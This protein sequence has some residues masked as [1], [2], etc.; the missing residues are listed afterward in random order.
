M[1]AL[2]ENAR[3]AHQL[4]NLHISISGQCQL[5]SDDDYDG[6][7]DDDDDDGA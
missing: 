1:Y 5:W 7:G 4:Q 2:A 3:T 6:D